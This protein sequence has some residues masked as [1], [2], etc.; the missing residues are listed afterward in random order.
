M[1]HANFEEFYM[2]TSKNCWNYSYFRTRVMSIGIEVTNP[3]VC[4]HEVNAGM[5]VAELKK[6]VD[7]KCIIE[8]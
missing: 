6:M 7:A 8:T 2:S 4:G 5:E 1:F 3:K